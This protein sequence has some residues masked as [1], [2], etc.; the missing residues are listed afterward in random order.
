MSYVLVKRPSYW[1]TVEWNSSVDDDEIVTNRVRLKFVRTSATEFDKWWTTDTTGW[2]RSQ[3]SAHNRE[4]FDLCVSNW[5]GIVDEDKKAL[6]FA[7]PY[8]DD[9]LET[10][11]FVGGFVRAYAEFIAALPKVVTGNSAAS[12]DGGP[13]TSDATVTAAPPTTADPLPTPSVNGAQVTPK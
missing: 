2:T 4:V 12:P 5:D 8:I 13:E 11:N 1:R 9:L 10:P 3:I 6:P 7:D